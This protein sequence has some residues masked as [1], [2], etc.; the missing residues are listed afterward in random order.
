MFKD[1]KA[2]QLY[3]IRNAISSMVKYLII[4]IIV[5]A[6]VLLFIY[7]FSSSFKPI[8]E[9]MTRPKFFPQNPTLENYKTLFFSRTPSRNFPKF[10]ANGLVVSLFTSLLSTIVAVF[11][12]YALSR[13]DYPGGKTIHRSMLFAYIFPTIILLVPVYK[14]FTDLGLIDNF[15]GLVLVYTSLAVPFCTWILVSFF[16]AIPKETEEAARVDGASK[17][18]AF[19]KIVLP[20]S[21]P[22]MVT[23]ATYAF[24]TAWGEYAFAS[25]LLRGNLSKTVPLGLVDFTADQYIEWG[26]LLG[27]SI[28]VIIPVFLLFL[29]ISGYFIKGFTAGAL[30]E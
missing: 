16:E 23:V 18:M 12:A 24:I 8:S 19:I 26:P 25:V 3:K 14:L 5:L 11:A 22:G 28:L 10:I 2:A 6:A 27:G 4:L 1:A 17:W 20:M 9:I 29:P 21:A 15:V 13:Y 30:K 7:I